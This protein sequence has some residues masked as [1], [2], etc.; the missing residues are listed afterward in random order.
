MYT[1]LL[2]SIYAGDVLYTKF[3]AGWLKEVLARTLSVG[4]K[5]SVHLF[6]M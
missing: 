1:V 3:R 4:N 2:Y 5:T 6:E